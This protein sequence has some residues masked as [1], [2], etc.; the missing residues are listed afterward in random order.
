MRLL[1]AILAAIVILLTAAWVAGAIYYS[2]IP[3]G[4]LG[5]ILAVSFFVAT[6]V[7]FALSGRRGPR[8]IGYFVIFAVIV[9]LWFQIPASNSR[10]WQPDV[11]MTPYATIDGDKIT[12]H[13][14]RNFNYRSETDFDPHW[15]TRV[16]DL[17]KLD[18]AD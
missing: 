10:D 11:A 18:S 6:I 7:T 14:I 5:T 8:L 17:T 9:V 15:E 3:N 4:A 16:Y 1:I 2:P 13:N 12:I